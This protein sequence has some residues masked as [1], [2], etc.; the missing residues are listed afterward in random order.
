MPGPTA[1]SNV[2]NSPK[3]KRDA[4]EP[5]RYSPSISP[6]TPL[7]NTDLPAHP[8]HEDEVAVTGEGSPRTVVAGQLQ[9]LNIQSTGIK[10]DFGKRNE[11]EAVQKRFRLT[12]DEHEGWKDLDIRGPMYESLT[13]RAEAGEEKE[14]TPTRLPTGEVLEE[15]IVEIPE[16][17]HPH[18]EA[19]RT[20]SPSP[21]KHTKHRS[22]RKSEPLPPGS[23]LPTDSLTWHDSEITGH[24][25]TDPL[26]DGYGING[27]GFRP[28][29]AMAH[30]R[31]QKRTQQIL[32]WRNREAREARQ[33]RSEKRRADSNRVADGPDIRAAE[34][35]RKVRFHEE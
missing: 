19:N 2:Y 6:S 32:E 22:R 24:A 14:E 18:V 31:K 15:A 30:A 25:P 7:L 11:G 20:R 27:I 13:A 23:S 9:N 5:V 12:D 26:D 29:P 3:R 16:T 35:R 17:P 21:K 34:E 1:G 28:T 4:P 8:F 10:L 33:K